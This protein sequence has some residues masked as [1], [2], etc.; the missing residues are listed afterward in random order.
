MNVKEKNIEFI[1]PFVLENKIFDLY[2]PKYNVIIEV[3]GCYWHS[4]NVQ[5]NDMNKQQ[6]RRW[7]NDRFKE[8]LLNKHGYKLIRVW[9]DE[10]NGN[11]LTERIYNI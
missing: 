3:D 9:E 4:K 5:I 10:I 6:L 8:N 1:T 11:T 2:I 7:K